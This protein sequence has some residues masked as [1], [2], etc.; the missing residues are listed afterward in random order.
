MIIIIR[1]LINII[2][3]IIYFMSL[4]ANVIVFVVD[5]S[6]I[7]IFNVVSFFYQWLVRI[8]NQHKLTIISH[9]KQKQFN[10][11]VMNFKNLSIYVQ[12]KIN[13]ILRVY[14]VFVKIY[15]DDIVVF[16]KTLIEHFAHFCDV[17]QLLKFYNIRLFSKKSYLKYFTI[18]LLRQK[19]NIFNLTIIS[20]KLTTIVNL[21]FLYTFK[22]FEDYFN[23][24][25]WL[26][27]YIT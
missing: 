19:I 16:N 15:V 24:I 12:R 27:N 14:R 4:Q 18:A 2:V 11:V 17:F 25:D 1:N 6:Y 8:A 22:N 21:Q 7:S 26:R 5:C 3:L 20:N 9:K 23:F 10:V 13:T